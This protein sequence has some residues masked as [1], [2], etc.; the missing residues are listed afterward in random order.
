MKFPVFSLLNREMAFA[1]DEFARDCPLQGRVCE[2]SVPE[3]PRLRS[4]FEVVK[5]A[6]SAPD[7]LATAMRRPVA[8]KSKSRSASRS[9]RR[10][11]STPR[12]PHQQRTRATEKARLANQA[13]LF[14]EPHRRRG[15]GKR[16]DGAEEE[17]SQLWVIEKEPEHLLRGV[18]SLRICV[19]SGGAATR[20]GMARS[21]ND[22]L[23]EDY[24]PARVMMQDAAVGAA[25]R[26]PTFL[27]RC[28]QIDVQRFPKLH[29]DLIAVVRMHR[30]IPVPMKNNRRDNARTCAST[31]AA[32]RRVPHCVLV[33]A[34]CREREATSLAAP[35]ARRECTPIAA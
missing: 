4:P 17:V 13:K 21:V 2:P 16:R 33:L 18:R 12:Q 19:G 22:P 28:P 1:R 10:G 23:L 8:R 15:P 14:S 32:A 3:S 27:N 20:P 34:H 6:K 35:Q 31:R 11:D 24:L 5:G 25:T 29:D 26:Y 9:G 30:R 7:T